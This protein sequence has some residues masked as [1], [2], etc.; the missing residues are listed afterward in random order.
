M[1]A[2]AGRVVVIGA[3]AA[4]LAAAYALT[5]RAARE[6]LSLDLRVLEAGPR[7]GGHVGT[8]REH[9]FAVETGPNAFL[10]G[11]PVADRLIDDLGLTP[12]L[13]NARPASRRRFLVRGGRLRRLPGGPLGLL[14]TR[15]LSLRGRLRMA[16]EPWIPADPPAH[17]ESVADF[18]R[19]RFGREAAERLADAFVAGT[20]A[21]SAATLS[22]GAAYPALLEM[23][24]RHGSV[25][26]AMIAR[27]RE[28]APAAVLRSFAGGMGTLVEALAARLAP[29]L[30]LGD[31]VTGVVRD[32]AEW[33]V[34]RGRGES[35]TADRVI[36]AVPAAAAARMLAECGPALTG[37]L[38]A[39][40]TA[41]LA[42]VGL[43]WPAD[44]LPHPLDGYGYLVP[45]QEG[46]LTLGMVWESCLFPGRAPAT[47]VLVRVLLG[48]A[49]A[50]GAATRPDTELADLAQQEA[51][52][53]LGVRRS[54]ERA[55]VFRWPDAIPQYTQGHRERIIAIR[56]ETAALDGLEVCGSSYD[57]IALTAA[58]AS[59][60][61]AAERISFS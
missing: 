21:G 26:R 58:L 3:G 20:S 52:R 45:G 15:A 27:R 49:R 51:A 4:G 37:A 11:E 28:G 10:S 23:E 41:G 33:R 30:S 7:A 38:S 32:G 44:D 57:G 2:R 50:P 19:R 54:P 5:Q 48:G 24:R 17:E 42:A 36:L 60:V 39:I 56:R 46:L 43:A 1:T 31:P 18:G 29:A 8:V 61:A 34:E 9:G 16:L 40:P 47:R 22:M 14:T 13:V 6:Q 25:V 12:E 55:W 59:G 35:I 53:M